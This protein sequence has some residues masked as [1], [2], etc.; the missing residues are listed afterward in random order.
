M[1]HGNQA[2]SSEDLTKAYMQSL[3]QAAPA[4]VKPYISQATPYVVKTVTSCEALVP[5]AHAGYERYC[6]AAVL[7]APYRLDLLVPSL[8]GLIMCFFGGS[9][10]TL[11]AAIEA[12]RMVGLDHQLKLVR[13]LTEDFKN[14]S[15]ASRQ[16][17]KLDLDNDG[18]ADVQQIS[19]RDLVQR[20]LMLFLKTVDPSRVTTCVAGMQSGFLAVVATLKL[21]FAKAIT[22][23]TAIGHVLEKPTQLYVVPAFEAV[24]PHDYQR[25][26][27]PLTGYVIKGTIISISWFLQRVISACHSAVRGGTMAARNIMEYLDR[28]HYVQIRAEDSLLDEGV[29]YAL[30]A[31]GL[32]FQLSSGFSLPFPLNVLLLP[33]SLAEW[34]LVWL[35]NG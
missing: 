29:G 1:D 15:V 22:L 5:L 34:A 27:Q 18:V 14:F 13:D 3:A 35:V 9:F 33:V 12:Y 31:L 28:M 11:I 25:W 24:L 4:S 10:V 16:D 32:W 19:G 7:V 26:A 20:K 23:G 6:E 2:P 30:A 17:D 8:L 21:E